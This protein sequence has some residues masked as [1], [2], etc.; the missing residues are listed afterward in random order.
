MIQRCTD[1]K[2]PRYEDWGGRGI[3]VCERWM[4][5]QGFA[6]FLADMGERPEGK[7]LDRKDNDGDYTPTNCRWA[8]PLQQAA[9]SRQR[10]EQPYRPP[11]Q[12]K[13][14]TRLKS[15]ALLVRLL[16]AE[17]RQ[18]NAAARHEYLT[19][20]PFVRKVLLDY[21]ANKNKQE[22]EENK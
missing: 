20:S 1:P 3:K 2:A 16:P 15:V 4:G 11:S 21:I 18:V 17:R 5:E 9:N 12:K 6:N 10:K 22:E 7:S 19:T 14:S 8:T 13:P